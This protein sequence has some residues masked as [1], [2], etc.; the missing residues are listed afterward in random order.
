MDNLKEA[1]QKWSPVSKLRANRV[2]VCYLAVNIVFKEFKTKCA[3]CGKK[4]EWNDIL[5]KYGKHIV[6]GLY[7]GNRSLAHKDCL[8][9]RSRTV[10]RG[11]LQKIRLARC[12]DLAIAVLVDK[13]GVPRKIRCFFCGK[14]FLGSGTNLPVGI[15]KAGDISPG[16]NLTVH[17]KN[18]VH[19][20]NVPGNWA[21]CHEECHRQ[22]HPSY[23][24]LLRRKGSG[25]TAHIWKGYEKEGKPFKSFSEMVQDA[26]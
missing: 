22:Y 16:F 24:A 7:K 26:E 8:S 9:G 20:D 19:S 12:R 25:A 3:V 15:Q 6:I 4:F 21:I 10:T 17:H 13:V 11:N 23:N 1:K 2:R 5:G 14:S 18:H